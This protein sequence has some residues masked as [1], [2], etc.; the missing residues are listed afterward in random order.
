MPVIIS[1]SNTNPSTLGGAVASSNTVPSSIPVGTSG[2]GPSNGETQPVTSPVQVIGLVP[3]FPCCVS[4]PTPCAYQDI[5]ILKLLEGSQTFVL[6]IPDGSTN[7]YSFTLNSNNS[8][9]TAQGLINA[10]LPAGYTC[11]VVKSAGGIFTI[12][13]NTI[14]ANAGVLIGLGTSGPSHGQIIKGSR[15]TFTCYTNGQT[16]VPA[17]ATFTLSLLNC[18]PSFLFQL[19]SVAN[20]VPHNTATI[21]IP[22]PTSTSGVTLASMAALVQA[23]LPVGFIVSPTLVSGALASDTA[24]VKFTIICPTGSGAQY[25][26]ILLNVIALGCLKLY[27]STPFTG[28]INGATATSPAISNN[29]CTCDCRYGKYRADE[30]PDDRNFTLPVFASPT[31]S[32]SYHN[33]TNTFIFQYFGNYNPITSNDFHLQKLT[34]GVFTNI[35]TLNSTAYGTPIY[36]YCQITNNGIGGYT[37]NWNL[38]LAAFGEGTYSFTVNG[39]AP[40]GA[41]YCFFSPPFC[42]KTWDCYAVDGTIKWEANYAGGTFGSVSTQGSKWSLCCGG[43]GLPYNDSIRFFGFFGY[44]TAEFQR[45][46]IKYS[47]GVITKIRDEAIESYM[48]K[49]D[50]LPM[51][52]HERFYAYGLMADQLYVSDYNLNNADYNLK[53]FYVVADSNYTPI[54]Q[55]SLRYMKVLDCKFK[56]GD[57]F[58]FRDRCCG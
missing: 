29:I 17:Q 57:Q 7:N 22:A 15:S 20:G 49:T 41:T 33:D 9:A 58:V 1:N 6:Q 13:L 21:T 56:K 44:R 48:M 31:C 30:I 26:G 35:A 28:G 19:Q 27:S 36:N 18:N 34:N 12:T 38:V 40:G 10:V 47:T 37:I 11:T 2:T 55:T 50:K 25:N 52:L 53:H 3:V 23:V 45:D 51:W 24:V 42:L 16:S 8:A 4:A 32:D 54:Y 5:L 43:A 14:A 46:F 39:T